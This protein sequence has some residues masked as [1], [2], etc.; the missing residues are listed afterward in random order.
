MPVLCWTVVV[1]KELSHRAKLPIYLSV[2]FPSF[3]YCHE[4]WIEGAGKSFL[5]RVAGLRD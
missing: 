1:K 5:Q 4:L 2:Y 3:S